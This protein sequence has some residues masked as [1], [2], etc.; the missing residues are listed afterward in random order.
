MPQFSCV[1]RYDKD[2]ATKKQRAQSCK[3]SKDGKYKNYQMCT[4]DCYIKKDKPPAPSSGSKKKPA[5]PKKSAASSS[6]KNGM[7]NA[8]KAAGIAVGVGLAVKAAQAGYKYFQ[9]RKK[10]KEKKKK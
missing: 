3:R 10:K 7:S 8:Q 5:V 4:E 9:N 6:K 1:N 2:T